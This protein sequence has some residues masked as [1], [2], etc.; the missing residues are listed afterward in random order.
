MVWKGCKKKAGASFPGA[1]QG[2]GEVTQYKT[3][4]EARDGERDGEEQEKKGGGGGK[5]KKKKK[6]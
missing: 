1:S 4:K 5:S 6:A 2:K 3:N